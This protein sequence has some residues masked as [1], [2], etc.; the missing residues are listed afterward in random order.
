V[1]PVHIPDAHALEAA[2]GAER[3]LLFKHSRR[4]P[5]SAAAFQEYVAFARENPDL[6]TGWIDVVQ[7]RPW[8]RRIMEVTGVPHES[9]QALLIRDGKVAWHASHYQINRESLARAL[10]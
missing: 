3:F 4:C 2:L 7:Q 9:P 10:R 6:H 1:E 5:V 8:A